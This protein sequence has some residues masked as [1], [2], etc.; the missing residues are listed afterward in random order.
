M[1]DLV[2]LCYSS[3]EHGLIIVIWEVMPIITHLAK[4]HALFTDCTWSLHGNLICLLKDFTTWVSGH[5]CD[6]GKIGIQILS[7]C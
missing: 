1:G 2:A 4:L 7:W 6:N 3:P 5:L